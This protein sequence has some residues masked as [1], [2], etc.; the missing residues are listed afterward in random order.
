[1]SITKRK[2]KN[3]TVYYA[4]VYINGV[5]LKAKTFETKAEAHIWQ[6]KE[7]QRLKQGK[8]FLEEE[9]KEI[10]FE[11]CV[12]KYLK[13]YVPSLKN[14]SQRNIRSLCERFLLKSPLEKVKMSDLN[15]THVDRWIQWLFKNFKDTCNRHSFRLEL[16]RLG[17]VL[18]WWRNYVD[19]TFLF[20]I[21][22]GHRDRCYLKLRESQMKRPDY[23]AK[24][25]EIR[26]WLGELKKI[27]NP[28][29]YR[30]AQFMILTGARVSEACGLMW[31]E[32]DFENKFARVVRIA[33]W[34][35]S[36][37]Q[38]SESTK[39]N[40]SVRV[41]TL[42]EKLLDLLS[43]MKKES[44]GNPLVFSSAEGGIVPY[45]TVRWAFDKSFKACGLPWRGT[46]ICRH[47]Y[48]TMALMA[49]KSLSAVQASLGHKDQQMTQRYAKVVALINSNMAEKTAQMYELK[50]LNQLSEAPA[51]KA[52]PE[53]EPKNSI[54]T[55]EVKGF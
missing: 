52:L 15:H 54:K 17:S 4:Q 27:K 39:T 53:P 22:Q 10:F 45:S 41:L 20:P 43:Q 29:Y 7:K 38:I 33:D 35:H 40:T 14:S 2:R 42:S 12:K 5:R 18:H 24:P 50:T 55:L 32:V 49:T 30:L 47:T 48:A 46:H 37:P 13:E 3:K 25:D 19:P 34:S 23:F 31:S 16:R 11:D 36:T 6:A 21:V 8:T 9:L 26:A 44:K 51:A 1:M 28:V